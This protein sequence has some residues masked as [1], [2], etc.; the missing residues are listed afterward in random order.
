MVP[1]DA[2][3]P[4]T[5]PPNT[6]PCGPANDIVKLAGPQDSLLPLGNMVADIDK[7]SKRPWKVTVAPGVEEGWWRV[8]L[9]TVPEPLNMHK[10]ML[11]LL[12]KR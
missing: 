7:I 9:A 11:R 3:A 6:C 2:N 4:S 5:A 8:T 12:Q 10:P 1:A